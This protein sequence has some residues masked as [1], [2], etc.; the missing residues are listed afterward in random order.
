MKLYSTLYKSVLRAAGDLVKDIQNS[1]DPE[2][3]YWD[4]ENRNDEDKMPR[5][6]L[7]G[8]NGFHFHENRGLWLINF[9]LTLSTIDDDNLMREAE[10]ID[11]VHSRFGEHQK[12]SMLDPGDGTVIS[13]L[14]STD[15]ETMPMPP[16]QLRNYRTIGVELKRTSSAVA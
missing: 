5:Q 8:V 6:T 3:L 4:W 1:V 7:V 12:I 13:E 10:I 16:T 11:M 9:G 2:A 14:V 15:F